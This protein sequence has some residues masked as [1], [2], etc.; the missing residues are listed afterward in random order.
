[1]QANMDV[2]KSIEEH[3]GCVWPEWEFETAMVERVYR[4]R[5]LP[6]GQLKADDIRLLIG[7]GIAEKILLPIALEILE[8]NPLIET[9][10]YSGDLL[11]AVSQLDHQLFD[12]C[13]MQK[14]KIIAAKAMQIG[15]EECPDGLVDDLTKWFNEIAAY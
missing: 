5:K 8:S 7:Q 10:Y 1:M 9:E 15:F 3:E 14:L 6:L 12:D 2:S 13:C 4:L 11:V